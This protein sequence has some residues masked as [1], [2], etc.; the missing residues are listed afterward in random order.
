[1][2]PKEYKRNLWKGV[3]AGEYQKHVTIS[4]IGST[5]ESAEEINDKIVYMED[6]E[7]RKQVYGICGEC[8]EPGTG[9]DWCQ[10][11]NA[12]RFKDNFKNWTNITYI[13]R[14]GFGKVYSAEWSEGYIYYWNIENQKWLRISNAKVA[15]KSLN[16][17]SYLSMEFLNEMCIRD[18][19]KASDIYSL[20]IMMNEY[21]S[22]ETPYNNIPHNHALAIK[23]CKGLRPNIF[24]YTPKLLADLITKCWDAKVENR[25]ITKELYQE[26]EKLYYEQS[27]YRSQ[28][29]EYGD[30][31][32]LN[33][34]SEKR[35]S[36]IQTH[37]QAIYTSRILN[38]K[39]LPEPVN[40]DAIKTTLHYSECLD[41]QLDE[42]DLN[43]I[44]QDE[45]NNIE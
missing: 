4:T 22:E 43:E 8:N 10:P 29:N 34:T 23:I 1:M 38:F 31:I 35:S 30:K 3:Y 26:L 16:N 6:L 18:S 11:C 39:N 9:E 25:P 7:K 21:I 42:L 12:K 20:G 13:T 27:K 17:S 44:N 28:I 32:K 33:R 5:T 14:G 15:L 24:K 37:P 45:E 19:T 40:S 36:N 2:N 41:C